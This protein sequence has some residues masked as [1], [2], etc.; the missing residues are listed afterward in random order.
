MWLIVVWILGIG[1]IGT[2]W[3]ERY[4]YRKRWFNNLSSLFFVIF[5]M[6]TIPIFLIYMAGRG[7]AYLIYCGI[8]ELNIRKRRRRR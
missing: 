4:E 2:I 5:W 1:I 7:I 6:V 3:E 8:D